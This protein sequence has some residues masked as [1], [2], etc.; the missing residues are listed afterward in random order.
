MAVGV[1]L[2]LPWSRSNDGRLVLYGNVD[3][4]EV[5][6]G[7]RVDGR[8]ARLELEEGDR[9]E[10]RRLLATLDA[11]PF[12]ADVALARAKVA[13]R[14]AELAKLETG[15]RPQDIERARATLAQRQAVLE[16]AQVDFERTRTLFRRGD[17]AE[18]VFDD[19]RTTRDEAEAAVEA[20]EAELDLAIEG[21]RSEDID[22]ARAELA[23]AEAELD[24]ARTALA[25][26]ELY[27]PDAAVVLS[28][29][30]ERGAIVAAG[31]PVYTLTLAD[32][33]RIR[34][35]I[36]EPELGRIALGQRVEVTTDTHPDRPYTG[37]ISF[38]SPTAEFTPRAVQTEALRS[39]LV[40]RLHVIVEDGDGLHQ[41]MPVT[42]RVPGPPA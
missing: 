2:A 13:A 42:V 19:A 41:G 21:P 16:R 5:D 15:T 40:Y 34:A 6:L 25:D 31:A 26:T 27:A 3:I 12:E 39:R 32:P 18:R 22:A 4:R 30:R 38:I 35:W 17:A 7:F 9:V 37:R 11:R 24:R 29:L 36:D 33:I 8:I 10:P 14:R 23:A 28:R 1:V 20:A